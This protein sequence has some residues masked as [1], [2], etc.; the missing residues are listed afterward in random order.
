MKE[1][2]EVPV[3]VKSNMTIDN[4][5]L[6]RPIMSMD[7]NLLSAFWSKGACI[8]DKLVDKE[9]VL[10]ELIDEILLTMKLKSDIHDPGD[11]LDLIR[12]HRRGS[13]ASSKRHC[14]KPKEKQRRS[15]GPDDTW[16]SRF[17]S[18][19]S[20][21]EP[22]S[23]VETMKERKTKPK[24]IIHTSK[25][26]KKT[27][28]H[29]NTESI[30]NLR[31]YQP[32]HGYGQRGNNLRRQE[33]DFGEE[34]TDAEVEM[35]RTDEEKLMKKRRDLMKM[36]SWICD[37][38]YDYIHY[39]NVKNLSEAEVFID[40]MLSSRIPVQMTF[41]VDSPTDINV[42]YQ[43]LPNFKEEYMVL[44]I[45]KTHCMVMRAV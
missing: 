4:P 33:E 39:E 9:D 20:I 13:T 44:N 1:T 12:N 32:L 10:D 42:T 18:K 27:Y 16:S 30:L 31:D 5:I 23:G 11:L 6:G 26:P 34:E 14:V 29:A 2:V 35:I 15:W 36:M 38:G 37:E 24:T 45:S 43:F 28:K 19:H 7:G 17:V 25:N 3:L 22:L 21:I 8:P 41:K 40:V